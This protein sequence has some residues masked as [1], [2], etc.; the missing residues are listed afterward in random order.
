MTNT[1]IEVDGIVLA[2]FGD[3]ITAHDQDEQSAIEIVEKMDAEEV[4]IYD[5]GNVQT[6]LTFTVGREHAKLTDAEH[7]RTMLRKTVPR[8]GVLLTKI[9]R[10]YDGSEKRWYLRTPAI[11]IRRPS[12][13]GV[14]TY[15]DFTIT[16]GQFLDVKPK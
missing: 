16:G 9:T 12:G 4:S 1:R 14:Y 2:D 10:N 7:Y 6:T 5:R 3:T 8:V 13:I 15:A 11:R